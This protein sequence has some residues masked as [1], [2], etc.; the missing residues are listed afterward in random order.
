MP[1]R[2]INPDGMHHS[3]AFS[4]AILLPAGARTLVIGGQNA[5][6]AQGQLVGKG[7]IGVQTAKALEN[8]QRCLEAAGAKL[9]QLVQVRI[10][11]AGESFASR[12]PTTWSRSKPS[13]SWTS[14]WTSPA[15]V[16]ASGYFTAE[17]A[18]SSLRASAW[19]SPWHSG[20]SRRRLACSLQKSRGRSAARQISCRLERV[21]STSATRSAAGSC[22]S[23]AGPERELANQ[24]T[25]ATAATPNATATGRRD[26]HAKVGG[27]S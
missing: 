2:H 22:R 27:R 6:D 9:E 17:S 3:P 20:R 26:R 15:R 10:Y 1:I 25:R 11:L 24:R 16:V 4:Q 5:V 18:M 21:R 23:A 14:P 19:Q 13:R 7:D 8:L 12:T